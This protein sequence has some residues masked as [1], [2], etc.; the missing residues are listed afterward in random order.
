MDK[1]TGASE[2]LKGIENG[3]IQTVETG[4]VLTVMQ[5][6]IRMFDIEFSYAA[7]AEQRK[8]AMRLIREM[9]AAHNAETLNAKKE[10][11]AASKQAAEDTKIL[12][13]TNDS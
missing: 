4:N 1:K 5:D 12:R 11:E 3:M 7:F 8:Q 2:L 10:S 13:F 6:G 9:V